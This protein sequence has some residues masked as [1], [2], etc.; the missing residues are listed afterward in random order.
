MMVRGRG[1]SCRRSQFAGRCAACQLLF[2]TLSPK[3]S[4]QAGQEFLAGL[5]PRNVLGLTLLERGQV[6]F[7]HRI[8]RR[9]RL[10]VSQPGFHSK[11]SQSALLG[12]QI[13]PPNAF[14]QHCCPRPQQIRIGPFQPQKSSP[15][16]QR[17]PSSKQ[18]GSLLKTQKSTPLIRQQRCPPGQLR[19]QRLPPPPPPPPFGKQKRPWQRPSQQSRSELQRPPKPLQPLFFRFRRLAPVSSVDSPKVTATAPPSR[20]PRAPRRDTR[21]RS[22]CTPTDS[23]SKESPSMSRSSSTPAPRRG[24]QLPL[25]TARPTT[26]AVQRT[27][28][29]NQQRF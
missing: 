18:R 19:L 16:A 17:S 24:F 6:D 26:T 8:W 28:R 12:R 2:G 29:H 1:S 23:R 27:L 20:V 22:R 10:L 11:S 4:K 25:L 5:P 15:N 21:S 7:N 9:G 14:S 13:G 3:H